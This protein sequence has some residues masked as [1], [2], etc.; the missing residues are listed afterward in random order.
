[1]PHPPSHSVGDKRRYYYYSSNPRHGGFKKNYSNG[2]NVPQAVGPGPIN[3]PSRYDPHSPRKPVN[4]NNNIS[5]ISTTPSTATT[6]GTVTPT[7]GVPNSRVGSR[8]NPDI[9]TSTNAMDGPLNGGGSRYSGSRFNPQS[10][11]RSSLDTTA[12]ANS[13]SGYYSRSNKWRMGG[14]NP[15][16]LDYDSPNI[17]NS[18]SGRPSFWKSQKRPSIPIP[19]RVSPHG[20]PPHMH[21]SRPNSPIPSQMGSSRVVTAPASIPASA[22]SST[23]PF[24]AP[25]ARNRP[26]QGRTETPAPR[27]IATSAR[28]PTAPPSKAPVPAQSQDQNQHQ[29]QTTSL[30]PTVAPSTVSSGAPFPSKASSSAPVS[31][32]SPSLSSSPSPSPSHAYSRTNA[33][34]PV[35]SRAEPLPPSATPVMPASSTA[36]ISASVPSKVATASE[37]PAPAPT[38]SVPPKKQTPT[39]ETPNPTVTKAV[40]DVDGDDTQRLSEVK[41]NP[42]SL[43]SSL[44]NSVP[45]QTRKPERRDV[46]TENEEDDDNSDNIMKTNRKSDSL[47]SSTTDDTATMRDEIPKQAEPVFKENFLSYEDYQYVYDPKVLKQDLDSLEINQEKKYNEPL[48]PLEACIFPMTRERTRLW[49]LKNQPWEKIIG[50]QH[51]RLNNPIK[52]LRAYP[53]VRQNI[54]MH[55]QALK[56]LL[57]SCI[58]KL[59]RHEYLSKL[60]LKKDV[61]MIDEEW[62]KKCKKMDTM[63]HELRK[64]EISRKERQEMEANE[65]E[66]KEKDFKEKEGKLLGSSR[67]RNRADFVDD[68]EMENVLLQIDPVYKHIQSAAEIPPMIIDPLQRNS[69]KFKDVNNLVTDKDGWAKRI[70]QDG[71]DTFAQHEHEL[72]VEAYLSFPKKFLKISNYLG[73]LRTPEECVLHYYRTKSTVDYKKLLNE[74]NKKRQKVT[75]TKR[76]K[77][78]ERANDTDNEGSM[79]LS[80]RED[81]HKESSVGPMEDDD[82]KSMKHIDEMEARFPQNQFIQ[83]QQSTSS[84]PPPQIDESRQQSSPNESASALKRKEERREVEPV[85]TTVTSAT[86]HSADDGNHYQQRQQQEKNKRMADTAE[87]ADSAVVKAFTSSATLDQRADGSDTTGEDG[88]QRKRHKHSGEHK[89]SYWSVKEATLFPDLLKY[90]G[91]QWSLISEKLGTKST[92]MVR[93]YYQRNA[94]QFGWKQ[95]VEEADFKRNATSSGSVQQ[96]QILLQ[97]E[98]T[99]LTVS[100]GVPSQLWPALGF[101]SNGSGNKTCSTNDRN[102]NAQ[103]PSAPG[104]VNGDPQSTSLTPQ[105]TAAETSQ[106]PFSSSLN[107][108]NKEP[109]F[110]ETAASVTGLPAPR[111]PSILLPVSSE[112]EKE[113]PIFNGSRLKDLLNHEEG[114]KVASSGS[115]LKYANEAASQPVPPTT[116]PVPPNTTTDHT[117][118][119]GAVRPQIGNLVVQELQGSDSAFSNNNRRPT[120]L[121]LLL[122]PEN[123]LPLARTPLAPMLPQKHYHVPSPL[124]PQS[125]PTQLPSIKNGNQLPLQHQQRQ[126]E[127]VGQIQQVQGLQQPQQ[128]GAS[129]PAPKIN[130]AMDPLGALA[131]VAS[132]SL[133][134]TD[135]NNQ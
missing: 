81:R 57:C 46:N 28:V 100:N 86:L 101:F 110:S 43:G 84:S 6:T 60:K 53:F 20:P 10:G 127:Q 37:N 105:A 54:I 104:A 8:Y 24:E 102:P 93:N 26:V 55:K 27:R 80:E 7:A 19:P 122:N 121:S 65:K 73:G 108:S 113:K 12:N 48:K 130:F 56:P 135:K 129:A 77:K 79:T 99:P 15:N 125:E 39:L 2:P 29:N 71:I 134:E 128:P 107:N 106:Q 75:T 51:H 44:I 38:P 85:T 78:R 131:A 59:K 16:K 87:N 69:F 76:N 109:L 67:R 91:S 30:E 132:E 64:E 103:E 118:L 66:K 117:Q 3:R 42:H 22:Q 25:V 124:V 50:H 36:S 4:T 62:Q 49:E 111:L 33:S 119:T 82:I 98:N 5:S 116:N 47:W 14:G 94:A 89:S 31:H 97:S 32:F 96:S 95:L 41:D 120:S 11:P 72:F 45:Q 13:A 1:M 52:D 61:F 112:N 17:G 123:D 18:P 74:K 114:K 68:A 40:K 88:Q 83:I 133:L 115:D 35:P 21:S 34:V 92:T 23:T 126:Q 90:F 58:S 9:G 63:S 70:K